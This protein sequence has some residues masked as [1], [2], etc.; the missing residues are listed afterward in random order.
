MRHATRRPS[1]LTAWHRRILGRLEPATHALGDIA[2]LY[3]ISRFHKDPA[4]K[5]DLDATKTPCL[6]DAAK[7]CIDF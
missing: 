7:I 2:D 4:R 3:S 1:P 6:R 5:E